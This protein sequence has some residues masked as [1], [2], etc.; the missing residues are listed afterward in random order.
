MQLHRKMRLFKR[1]VETERGGETAN[2]IKEDTRQI[3]TLFNLTLF[4]P[5]PAHSFSLGKSCLGPGVSLDLKHQLTRGSCP[6][7][8]VRTS[9]VIHRAFASAAGV[10]CTVWPLF[11]NVPPSP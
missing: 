3:A 2:M 9:A 6:P 1:W 7:G 10:F 5:R 4:P 8:D 11:Q